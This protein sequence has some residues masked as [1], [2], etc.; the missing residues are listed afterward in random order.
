MSYSAEIPDNYQQKCLC[1][2]LLDISGSMVIDN[3]LGKLNDA[4]K[5][6]YDDII[7]GRNSVAKSTVNQLE[8]AIIAFD[9]SPKIIRHPKLLSRADVAPTLETRGSTTDTVKAV[10]KALDMIVARKR[11]YDQTGQNY[12]R[13]WIVLITDGEPTSKSEDIEKMA[14][15][16]KELET[17]GSIAMIGVSVAE[18]AT[19]KTLSKLSAGHATELRDYR[20]GKFFRWLGK[21]FSTIIKSDDILGESDLTRDAYEWMKGHKK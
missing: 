9:Q 5:Q 18:T 2:L 19:Q 21:S 15:K 4:I 20:F 3:R 10:D 6:F 1:V 17:R 14:K 8:V 11:F 12:Y 13:P 16:L 7:Y